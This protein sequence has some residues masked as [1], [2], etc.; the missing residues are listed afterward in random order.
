MT[1]QIS[2]PEVFQALSQIRH[3]EI[4][5]RNLVELGMI[6]E[7][8]V[9]GDQILVILALPSE[10]APIKQGLVDTIRQTVTG[11]AE[12]LRVEVRVVEMNDAQRAAFQSVVREELKVPA[13]PGGRVRHVLAV[14]SGKGG[15]GKSSVAG[16]TGLLTE[17]ARSGGRNSRCRYHRSEYPEDVW[18]TPT[19]GWRARRDPA[20]RIPAG[21]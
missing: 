10:E 8:I 20:G 4:K 6:L 21:D 19:T 15:V 7:V 9:E 1:S 3:P 12:R 2:R 13:K 18:R 11:L 14:M 5:S 17:K 16:I